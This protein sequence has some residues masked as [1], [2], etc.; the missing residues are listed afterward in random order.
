MPYD[1]QGNLVPSGAY[2]L[3][4]SQKKCQPVANMPAQNSQ[5]SA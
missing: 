4:K 1:S 2:S 3:L 5:T